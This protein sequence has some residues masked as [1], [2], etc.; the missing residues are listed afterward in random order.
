MHPKDAHYYVRCVEVRFWGRV[1]L[2]YRGLYRESET[3][4]ELQRVSK[5]RGAAL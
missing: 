4:V 5:L 2:A 3:G 1:A